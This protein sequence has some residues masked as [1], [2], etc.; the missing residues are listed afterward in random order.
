MSSSRQIEFPKSSKLTLLCVDRLA[1]NDAGRLKD[2]VIPEED[3]DIS[4]D[5]DL[6]EEVAKTK[7]LWKVYKVNR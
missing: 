4:R 5:I 7:E 2:R 3:K 1:N 6:L